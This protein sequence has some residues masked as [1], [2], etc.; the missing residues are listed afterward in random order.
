MFVQA[1]QLFI[2]VQT[3]ALQLHSSRCTA[4]VAEAGMGLM[5]AAPQ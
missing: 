3:L 5:G 1:I 4:D 2:W